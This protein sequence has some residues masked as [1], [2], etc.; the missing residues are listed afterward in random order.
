MGL[1]REPLDVDFYFDPAPLTIEE[2][3]AISKYISEYKLKEKHK[4]NHKKKSIRLI[5]KRQ[6][7]MA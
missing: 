7:Q 4:N 6:K 5:K 3:E 2:K 1:I